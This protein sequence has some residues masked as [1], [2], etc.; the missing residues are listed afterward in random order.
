MLTAVLCCA[1][2]AGVSALTGE[3]MKELFEQVAECAKDYE[4]GYK[5]GA[6]LGLGTAWA[7]LGWAGL[8]C[9]SWLHC[10]ALLAA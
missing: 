2:C 1:C 8:V 5:V 6:G 4:T 3:G 10:T 9:T 7:R